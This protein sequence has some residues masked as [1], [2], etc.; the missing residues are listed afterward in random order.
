MMR[1]CGDLTKIRLVSYSIPMGNDSSASNVGHDLMRVVSRGYLLM[2][3][4]I[5][6][7]VNTYFG[8]MASISAF[9]KTYELYSASGHVYFHAVVLIEDVYLRMHV[10]SWS[11][12][13]LILTHSLF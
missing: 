9:A 2:C 3:L 5:S 7:A 11:P 13:L 1:A 12:L 10:L 6:S 8:P 4:M